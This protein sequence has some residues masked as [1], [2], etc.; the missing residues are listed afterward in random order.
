MEDIIIPILNSGIPEDEQKPLSSDTSA[1][2]T[3]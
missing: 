3:S 1:S 2:T